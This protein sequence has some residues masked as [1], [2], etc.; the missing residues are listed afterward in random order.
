[1]KAVLA[2]GPGEF[3]C[4]D[5]PAPPA[6]PGGRVLA[7]EA[8]G[9][10][11]ADR[12]IWA[13]TGPWEL[14][15]PFVPGHEILG[16]DLATGERLTAEVAIPCGTCQL[17]ADGRAHLCPHAAHLGSALPGGFAQQVALPATARVHAVPDSLPR[18]AAVL[19]EPMAC[20]VHAVRRAGVRAGATVAVIGLGAVGALA[21]VAARA[22]D[23]GRILAVVRS[24]AKADLARRLGAEPVLAGDDGAGARTGPVS[25]QAEAVIECSGD[26]A[27]GD[28]A[29]R[30]AAPGGRVCLYSVYPAP[31]RLDLNQISEFKELTVTGGHL[32]PGCFPEAISLL[33]AVPAAAHAQEIA[34]ADFRR[35]LAGPRPRVKAALVP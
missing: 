11:A 22:R 7:V 13:G 2:S 31:A 34:L 4:L 30:L 29:L 8:A 26:A 16:R 21:V 10:C 17:C 24:Q 6:P 3:A 15:W 20:A 25:G 33:A 5:M 12:M 35:A 18:A 23:A 19:A 9:V 1:M 28:L 32:A 14:T 27:A